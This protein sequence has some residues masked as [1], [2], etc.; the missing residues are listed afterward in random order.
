VHVGLLHHRHQRSLGAPLRLEQAGKVA[1]I[2]HPWHLD[3]DA[4]HPRIPLALAVAVALARARGGALVAL[5][6]Q[7]LGHLQLHHR[8]AQHAHAFTQKVEIACLLCLAQQPLQCHT[9]RIGHRV[10]PPHLVS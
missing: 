3:H 2:A 1:A 4:A 9:Q 6:A 7:M 5:G 10:G 8:L